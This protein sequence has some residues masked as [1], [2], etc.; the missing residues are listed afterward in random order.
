[1]PI[2]V[3]YKK[4]IFVL[5]SYKVAQ[6]TL[7][8][9]GGA[10]FLFLRYNVDF[11]IF[12]HFVKH[13]H[14]KRYQIIR[15]PYHR[16]SSLFSDKFRK[17]PYKINESG[18]KWQP[19]HYIVLP[20]LGLSQD[21]P[22]AQIAEAFLKMSIDDFVEILPK[23]YL[24]EGHMSPQKLTSTLKLTNKIYLPLRINGFYKIEEHQK[25]I[26]EITSIDFKIKRNVTN[27]EK[28]QSEL[29]TKAIQ[30]IN[31]LYKDDFILGHYKM[32]ELDNHEG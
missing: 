9:E 24:K 3:N 14:F 11:K 21:D 5:T 1:M 4:N 26:T 29:T 28:L 15:N 8:K 6:T 31:N 18:F 10:N 22:N 12:K 7:R 2:F 23:I 32:K 13:Y 16:F 25:Q 30:V 17:Q 19:V 20:F 27:S